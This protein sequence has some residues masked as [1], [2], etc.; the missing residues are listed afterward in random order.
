MS[1][2]NV[3]LGIAILI[4]TISVVAYGISTFYETPEYSDFCNETRFNGVIETPENCEDLGGK[5]SPQ[6]IKCVTTP[7]PQGYCDAEYLCRQTYEAAREKH[8]KIVFLI[9]VPLGILII[10]L[11]ALIFGLDFVGAGLMGG[12]VGVILYGVGGFWQFA[13]DWIK[14]LLS[15]VGLII[16]I[17]FAYW[18]DKKNSKKISKKRKK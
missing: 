14:F 18:F 5:W 7:C 1:I 17:W 11:G 4:L 13:E 3:V 15:L 2:K 8:A 10:I 6:D 12:G 16:L 9:A